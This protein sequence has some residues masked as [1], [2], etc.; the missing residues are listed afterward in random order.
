MT[1]TGK[2]GAGDVDLQQPSLLRK[3]SAH[4]AFAAYRAGGVHF[5]YLAEGRYDKAK[6]EPTLRRQECLSRS[7][8]NE[9]HF[10]EEPP[11]VGG[12][13]FVK[14]LENVQG[15]ERDVIFFSVCYGADESG[16]IPMNFGPPNRDGGERR[17]NVAITRSKDEVLVFSSLFGD[18]LDLTRT[19]TQGAR[20]LKF[21]LEYAEGGPKAFAERTSLSHSG[22]FDSGFKTLVAERIRK[23]GYEVHH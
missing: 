18:H 7:L 5:K 2:H 12:S 8:L 4:F 23:A 1:R 22:E 13:G 19:R 10:E 17:L 14:N 20:D 15:D 21:F 6:P 3:Q 16:R 11:V 9:V